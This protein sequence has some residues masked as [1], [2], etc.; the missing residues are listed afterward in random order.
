MMVID[1]RLVLSNFELRVELFQI[2]FLEL[3]S[4]VSDYGGSYTIP[5]DDVVHNEHSH[6]LA[7]CYGEGDYFHP[8]GKVIH[9]SDNEL[10]SI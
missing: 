2:L 7:I 3:S 4:I 6:Y 10:V 9:G 8:L 1:G 5:T